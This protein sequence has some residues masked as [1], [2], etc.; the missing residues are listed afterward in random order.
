MVVVVA[1]ATTT[2]LIPQMAQAKY[3]PACKEY[4][5]DAGGGN[6]SEGGPPGADLDPGNSSK[7]KAKSRD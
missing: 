3:S 4:R 7:T 2:A 6:K 5:C 1:A